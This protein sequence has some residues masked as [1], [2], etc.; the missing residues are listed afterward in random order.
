MARCE[1]HY[2]KHCGADWSNDIDETPPAANY[3][4]GCHEWHTCGQCGALRD[5]DEETREEFHY[6]VGGFSFGGHCVRNLEEA[7]EEAGRSGWFGG[8]Q[9]VK[10]PGEGYGALETVVAVFKDG[11][12]LDHPLLRLALH[13]LRGIAER[14]GPKKGTI[15]AWEHPE[16]LGYEDAQLVLTTINQIEETLNPKDESGTSDTKE[17]SADDN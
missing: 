16:K 12:E 11:R 14:C 3:E 4:H 15:H 9:V 7:K 10:K 13:T 8:T 1:N 17:N 5:T 6:T 2:C